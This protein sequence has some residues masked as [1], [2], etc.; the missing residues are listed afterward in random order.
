MIKLQHDNKKDKGLI[1]GPGV[2]DLLPLRGAED[3]LVAIS[4]NREYKVRVRLPGGFS[5]EF[6]MSQSD[7]GISV[8]S[9]G[10]TGTLSIVNHYCTLHVPDNMID[11]CV[12]LLP[13]PLFYGRPPALRQSYSYS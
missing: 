10:N 6:S 8:A 3:T 2:Y 13:V 11:G 5:K 12:N 9:S 7:V 1:P 4:S